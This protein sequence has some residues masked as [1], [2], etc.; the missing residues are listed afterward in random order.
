MM[1]MMIMII[2]IIISE[3]TSSTR[4]SKLIN[5]SR[6]KSTRVDKDHPRPSRRKSTRVDNIVVG[7]VVDILRRRSNIIR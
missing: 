3:S 4:V 1:I 5:P 6:R 2:M 7:I